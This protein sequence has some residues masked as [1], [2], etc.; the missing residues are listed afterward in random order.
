MCF[1]PQHHWTNPHHIDNWY[2]ESG[3]RMYYTPKL[4]PY[5][6]SVLTVG[7]TFLEIP[8]LSP[9]VTTSGTM[10]SGCSRRYMNGTIHVVAALNHMHY[11]GMYSC[12]MCYIKAE[13]IR[14][15][16]DKS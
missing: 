6:A 7:Q 13:G 1:I 12:R 5:D 10:T 14:T 11:L 15:N 2:D 3:M 9:S 8:P 16:L 4:R